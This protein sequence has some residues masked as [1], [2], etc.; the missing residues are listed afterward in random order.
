LAAVSA[1]TLGIALVATGATAAGAQSCGNHAVTIYVQAE[2][3]SQPPTKLKGQTKN[4]KATNVTCKAAFKFLDALYKNS[5][6]PENF[7][8]KVGKGKEP[9]GYFPQVCTHGAKK[10]EYGAQGG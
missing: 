1:A 7:K 2:T 8:C 9:K 10:I 6:A 3:P 4:V 5:K